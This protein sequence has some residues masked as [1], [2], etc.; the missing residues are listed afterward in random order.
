ML[1]NRY[2]F[3]SFW[4][5]IF[6]DISQCRGQSPDLPSWIE[7]AKLNPQTAFI[8]YGMW[9]FES[10]IQN[11]RVDEDLVTSD[12]LQM[13]Q[14]LTQVLRMDVQPPNETIQNCIVACTD[15]KDSQDCLLLRY[16]SKDMPVE[17]ICA[18]ALYVTVLPENTSQTRPANIQDLVLRAALNVLNYP[19]TAADARKELDV[20]VSTLQFDGSKWGTIRWIADDVP[21][22]HW[23]SQVQWWSDGSK[24]LFQIPREGHYGESFARRAGFAKDRQT[25]VRF[26]YRKNAEERN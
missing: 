1:C 2:I 22:L 18:G 16:S 24:I 25:K 21:Y 6:T 3:L 12:T 7:S 19:G 4:I 5:L 10:E 17:I 11:Q 8:Y 26:I 23:Y 13:R 15:L 9:P 14:E 20:F